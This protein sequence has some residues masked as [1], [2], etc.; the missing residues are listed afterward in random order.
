MKLNPLV[1]VRAAFVFLGLLA[2]VH[3]ADLSVDWFTVDGGGATDC[4]AGGLSL[5]G[6]VGQPDTCTMTAAALALTGG[7]WHAVPRSLPGDCSG[8]GAVDIEDYASFADCLGGPG[9]TYESHCLC[10]DIDEDG[11][12]DL[13]DFSYFQAVFEE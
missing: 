9:E 13:T 7:F 10:A 8:D 4:S 2:C 1:A 5:K 6:T 11:D 12:V 3:A